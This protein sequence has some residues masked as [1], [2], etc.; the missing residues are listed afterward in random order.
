M[1]FLDSS[2]LIDK[3][4][5]PESV[6]RKDCR[7][8]FYS[9]VDESLANEDIYHYSWDSHFNGVIDRIWEILD[10]TRRR[11]LFWRVLR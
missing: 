4:L 2:A 6:L 9:T 7:T 8:E 11:F 5:L 1:Y 10:G 3:H